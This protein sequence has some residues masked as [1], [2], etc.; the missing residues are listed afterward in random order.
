MMEGV[1]F[2]GLAYPQTGYWAQCHAEKHYR[3]AK[4]WT[5]NVVRLHITRGYYVQDAWYRQRV[6]EA[7]EWAAKYGLYVIFDFYKWVRDNASGTAW[8][9]QYQ[10]TVEQVAAFLKQFVIENVLPYSHAMIEVANQPKTKTGLSLGGKTVSVRTAMEYLIRAVRSTG[11]D[12][13]I[14]AP[15]DGHA[16]YFPS[17]DRVPMSD[18]GVIRFWHYYRFWHSNPDKGQ[19]NVVT[20]EQ[21]ENYMRSKGVFAVAEHT[22]VWI[23][24]FNAYLYPASQAELTWLDNV[25][26][27]AKAHN[28]HFT[29][30]AWDPAEIPIGKT[31]Q[32]P[33]TL[34]WNGTPCP[35][36]VILQ[37]YLSG[38]APPPT[39]PPTE[40]DYETMFIDIPYRI[41]GEGTP[42]AS[43]TSFNLN[44]PSPLPKAI[45][46][47][48]LLIKIQD[49]EWDD[50]GSWTINQNKL[51]L[52]PR[53]GD[54]ATQVHALNI[55]P[56]ELKPGINQLAFGYTH[57]T[58]SYGYIIHEA[59]VG[60]VYETNGGI[61]PPNGDYVTKEEFMAAINA[62]NKRISNLIVTDGND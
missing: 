37:K 40:Y 14:G 22:P 34:D 49:T 32:F 24:E 48:D 7:V 53:T 1:N 55:P 45:D 9:F 59:S 57:P 52:L 21:V 60:L 61:P 51:R 46:Y 29:A 25:L 38:D 31:G 26:K 33:L 23:G 35:Q 10:A 2:R 47:A 15:C 4:A 12:R 62:T 17:D 39:P 44:L 8:G 58:P 13:A 16:S 50:E 6:R 30:W 41:N 20:Y 19:T 43:W 54:Q 3:N 11:Y 36:G 28:L 42:E 27:V 5:S 18:D 56:T